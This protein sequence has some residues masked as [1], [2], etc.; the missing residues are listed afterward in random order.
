MQVRGQ[1]LKGVSVSERAVSGREKTPGT[2]APGGGETARTGALKAVGLAGG[3]CAVVFLLSW[4]DIYGK[5]FFER[6][7]LYL[8]YNILRVILLVYFGCIMYSAGAG[9]LRLAGW[10]SVTAGL[11]VMERFFL[12]SVLGC[13]LVNLMMFILGW[14][15]LLYRWIAVLISSVILLYSYADVR[16][17]AGDVLGRLGRRV[18]EQPASLRWVF[19]GQ[20]LL[21]LLFLGVILVTLAL[22]PFRSTDVIN[23]YHKYFLAVTESHNIWPNDIWYHFYVSKGAGLHIMGVL[24]GDIN[25]IPLVSFFAFVLS[26]CLVVSYAWRR[27]HSIFWGTAVFFLYTA[28]FLTL[29]YSDK[30]LFERHHIVTAAFIGGVVWMG[31]LLP[32]IERASR[33]RWVVLSAIVATALMVWA[34]TSFALVLPYLLFGWLLFVLMFKGERSRMLG[35][36]PLAAAGITALVLG[37]NYLVTG[38][39][40][41]TPVRLF[42]KFGDL[43]RFSAWV[44]PYLMMH[45]MEGS[46]PGLGGVSGALIRDIASRG[47]LEGLLR[48]DRISFMGSPLFLAA[49]A[50]AAVAG[51]WCRWKSRSVRRAAAPINRSVKGDGEARRSASLYSFLLVLGFLAI[52]VIISPLTGQYVSTCR[53]YIF[54]TTLIVLLG[55]HLAAFLFG[56]L[57]SRL[58]SAFAIAICLLIA[59]AVVPPLPVRVSYVRFAAGRLSM[60]DFYERYAQVPA[61]AWE[62]L[63]AAGP[64]ERIWSVSDQG[65]GRL[66]GP[67]VRVENTMGSRMCRNWHVVVFEDPGAASAELRKE[68]LNY[69]LLDL[70][71]VSYGALCY[72]P[73]F[74][75]ENIGR[76]FSIAW[77]RGPIYLLSWREEGDEPLPGEFLESWASWLDSESSFKPLYER[78][79]SIYAANDGRLYPIYRDPDLPPVRGWQ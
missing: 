44:S 34:P 38:L 62:I 22:A 72:S 16:A 30:L 9:F 4:M 18:S 78:M 10:R 63:D 75:P 35:L 65:V 45:I 23:H 26:A 11:G 46:G 31:M 70:E 39:G 37:T 14:S 43:S 21:A 74:A 61:F 58:R 51:C 42:W 71:Q 60:K 8:L 20:L 64:G 19:M 47:Y 76:S 79:K 33:Y 77:H 27:M 69:F 24:L 13:S 57:P 73:L 59:M 53:Y 56:R 1:P 29:G 52:A 17:L 48:L 49:S 41:A 54:A 32:E 2:T 15:N 28:F 3:F 66:L 25:S 50:C 6:T 5:H 68:K 40:E 67:G 55:V 12:L 36:V 7:P